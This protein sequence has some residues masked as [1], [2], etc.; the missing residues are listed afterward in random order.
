[1]NEMELIKFVNVLK[2]QKEQITADEM[3]I[4]LASNGKKYKKKS[5]LKAYARKLAQQR[6][7]TFK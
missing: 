6:K 2:K 3:R 5:A 4:R 1:M 7:E